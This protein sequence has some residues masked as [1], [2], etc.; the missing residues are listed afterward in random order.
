M[1][2]LIHQPYRPILATEA[3]EAEVMA[4]EAAEIVADVAAVTEAEIAADAEAATAA[5]A[6]VIE[7]VVVTVADAIVATEVRDPIMHL[8]KLAN[9]MANLAHLKFHPR[10]QSVAEMKM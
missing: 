1:R 6:A 8:Q 3:V 2:T 10:F 7:I 4:V 5:E 9:L